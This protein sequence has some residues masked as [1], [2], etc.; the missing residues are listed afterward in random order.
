VVTTASQGL[1]FATFP[2]TRGFGVGMPC[3]SSLWKSIGPSF[4]GG[5]GGILSTS[6]SLQVGLGP[7][8]GQAWLAY[9]GV[10]GLQQAAPHPGEL[11]APCPNAQTLSSVPL[12]SF[13]KI[14]HGK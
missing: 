7:S 6:C 1:P 3:S 9:W 4:P 5:F 13:Q 8:L 12:C 10:V 2:V 11:A 14:S